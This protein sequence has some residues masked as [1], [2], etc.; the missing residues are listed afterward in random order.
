M[1]NFRFTS[2][3]LSP[4]SKKVDQKMRCEP[5]KVQKF[6]FLR[7]LRLF[8]LMRSKSECKN[9]IYNGISEYTKIKK[10]WSKNGI[11][12]AENWKKLNFKNGVT[13]A[14][15][16]LFKELRANLEKLDTLVYCWLQK[17]QQKLT[18]NCV[19]SSWKSKKGH[20]V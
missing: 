15:K 5:L 4:K 13:T 11:L 12:A 9:W 3:S 1:S 18:K 7:K 6:P 19:V 14:Q 16:P 2:V 20:Q 17:N 8:F 10:S